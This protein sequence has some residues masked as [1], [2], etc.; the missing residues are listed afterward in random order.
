MIKCLFTTE[1]R[2][3]RREF[4]TKNLRALRV[5]VVN[6]LRGRGTCWSSPGASCPPGTLRQHVTLGHPLQARV[7]MRPGPRC[8]RRFVQ[9]LSMTRRKVLALADE[10]HV[11]NSVAF[12]AHRKAHRIGVALG[13]K[14]AAG[15][16]IAQIAARLQLFVAGP[17][18]LVTGSGTRP[19]PSRA[20]RQALRKRPVRLESLFWHEEG[21][22]H[23]IL[24]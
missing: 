21:T 23:K 4:D 2:R 11:Q 24:A 10:K 13:G 14:P 18:A 16:G 8:A 3:S 5:S 20:Q 22:G 12:L 7:A 15:L 17:R 9:Q 19:R 6:H 1:A